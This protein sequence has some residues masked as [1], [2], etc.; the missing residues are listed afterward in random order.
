MMPPSPC[1]RRRN[2]SQALPNSIEES[3]D[4]WDHDGAAPMGVWRAGIVLV[5][6]AFTLRASLGSTSARRELRDPTHDRPPAQAPDIFEPNATPPPEAVEES[7]SAEESPSH[8]PD[9]PEDAATA[10]PD[11]EEEASAAKAEREAE[12]LTQASRVPAKGAPLKR[13]LWCLG[14]Q[15]SHGDGGW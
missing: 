6:I 2:R 10:R 15:V 3:T 1:E 8:S 5:L 7:P 9:T 13:L 11:A 14:E 4:E 12:A